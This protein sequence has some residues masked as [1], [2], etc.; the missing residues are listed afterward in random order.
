MND[1]S[2][3][4]PKDEKK[5]VIGARQFVG[6]YAASIMLKGF[7][8]IQS[9][10]LAR[11]LEPE[12]RGELAAIIL[13]P[14]IVAN[15]GTLGTGLSTTRACAAARGDVAPVVRAS[16]MIAILLSI[17]TT[18][19]GLVLLPSLVPS[20]N[21]TVLE[22]AKIY[23]FFAV[24]ALIISA[25]LAGVDQ[26]LG[27]FFRVNLFRVMQSP[28]NVL[29]LVVLIFLAIA[30]LT[31]CLWAL[32][33]SLWFTTFSRLV[34][35]L[36]DYPLRGAF[37]S[38]RKLLKEGLPYAVVIVMGQLMQRGDQI[39]LLWLLTE[40][41]LG[42]YAVAYSAASIMSNLAQS[43]GLV[44]LTISAQEKVGEGFARVAKIFRGTLILSFVVGI[45]QV[46]AV[47]LVLP[48]LY[49]SEFADARILSVVLSAG[50]ILLGAV[51]V[52][53]QSMRGQGKPLVGIFP[54][55]LGILVMAY[56]AYVLSTDYGALG[57]AIG[58]VVAQIV[59]IIG[60]SVMTVRHYEDASM[61]QM[62]P[63]KRDVAF[64]YQRLNHMAFSVLK[65]V[66]SKL[67]IRGQR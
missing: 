12:G 17:I 58:F 56:V 24:P 63:A 27:N 35:V 67:A 1:E 23:M 29:L 20:T 25:N 64:V 28:V 65:K 21:S 55:L 47:Y 39:L 3:Q 60:W 4:N 18:A 26:G 31:Y 33:I 44:T 66:R 6:T 36:R 2:Q 14:T 11:L 42:L 45:A 22:L 53:T 61:S 13:W 48:I 49:G 50:I 38:P 5:S 41:D 30:D 46:V 37:T 10:I 62:I 54:N 7:T 51:S 57:V 15:I 52:L 34:L 32:I 40:R 19:I 9:V 59:R 43:M 16:L 8:L